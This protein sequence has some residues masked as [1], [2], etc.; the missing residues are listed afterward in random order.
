[1]IPALKFWKGRHPHY[2]KNQSRDDNYFLETSSSF[3]NNQKMAPSPLQ[4]RRTHN[5]LLFQKLLNLR[6]G[7]SPFTLVLDTLEQS[8]RTVVK[9]FAKRAKVHVSILSIAILSWNGKSI[10][11]NMRRGFQGVLP[12]SRTLL[13]RLSKA[14]H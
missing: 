14:A 3:S 1:M 11:L 9:E 6:D 2:T 4:Q 8:G 7:A 12:T 10:G 13:L 5:T